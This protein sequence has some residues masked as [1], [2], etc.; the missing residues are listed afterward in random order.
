MLN[1]LLNEGGG[2]WIIPIS[3]MAAGVVLVKA[4]FGFSRSRGQDRKD[5]LDLWAKA[6]KSDDLWLQVAVRHVFGEVLPP[7]LIRRFLAHPQGARA[8]GDIAYAWPLLDMDEAT[9]ELRWR[10]KRHYSER[11]RRWEWS[12]WIATYVVVALAMFGFAWIA[13]LSG[14]T[15]MGLCLWVLAV[16][17]GFFAGRALLRAG[18]LGDA[19]ESVPRW[20]RGLTWKHGGPDTQ[21]GRSSR[22]S[23]KSKSRRD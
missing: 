17:A 10:R 4:L 22:R 19:H 12:A 9:G 18:R 20:T 21:L 1:E 14:K 23:G 7:A 5:F 13:V 3:M 8:L 6:D 2:Q 16:E 15:F 11:A